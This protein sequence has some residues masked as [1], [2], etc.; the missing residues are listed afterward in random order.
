MKLRLDRFA[1]LL[2]MKKNATDALLTDSPGQFIGI[3][4]KTDE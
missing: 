1:R 3:G 2:A 4:N